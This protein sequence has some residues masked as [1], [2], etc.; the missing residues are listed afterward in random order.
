MKKELNKELL[1][2]EAMMK[3]VAEEEA[4]EEG[5]IHP[6]TDHVDQPQLLLIQDQEDCVQN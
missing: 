4:E 6:Q 5:I 1:L 2:E 3:E